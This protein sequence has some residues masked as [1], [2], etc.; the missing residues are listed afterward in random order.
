MSIKWIIISS[1]YII[2]LFIFQ[3]GFLLKKPSLDYQSKCEDFRGR[4][5]LCWNKPSFKKAIWIIIDALRYD[6]MDSGG[7]L[8]EPYKGRVKIAG[9]LINSQPNNTILSLFIADPPTTTFQRIKALTTGSLPTFIDIKDNFDAGSIDEDNIINQ[10]FLNGHNIT[11]MGDDTWT[12]LFKNKFNR[13]FPAPSFDVFDLDTVDNMVL[14]HLFDEI[15]KDD[16]NIIIGHFLG[17]D[18]CGHRYGPKHSAMLEKLDQMDNM[19]R[20]IIKQMDN[21]TILF[22]MGDHGMSNDG[23]HGGDSDLEVEAGFLAYS[24]IPIVHGKRVKK[25]FQIDF[26]PTISFLL[27]IPLP[28][29]N[30]GVVVETFFPIRELLK[31]LEINIAQVIR[32]ITA[33][34]REDSGMTTNFQTILQQYNFGLDD[35]V[36]SFFSILYLIQEQLRGVWVT[37]D[38]NLIIIGVLM[39]FDTI[40]FQITYDQDITSLS[41]ITFRSG[42]LLLSIS[43]I[44]MPKNV[45]TLE[46]IPFAL[47][48]S[49]LV[50]LIKLIKMVITKK[51]ILTS[52]SI[53]TS[54]L[55][56]F[57]LLSLF[58][59]SYI[60]YEPY[61][62]KFIIQ[63]L[64]IYN[65][66]QVF[67]QNRRISKS[68]YFNVTSFSIFVLFCGAISSELFKCREESKN[69]SESFLVSNFI[70]FDNIL[71][72]FRMIIAIGLLISINLYILSSQLSS[73]NSGQKLFLKLGYFFIGIISISWILRFV[74]NKNNTLFYNFN[75]YISLA[76]HLFVLSSLLLTLIFSPAKIFFTTFFYLSILE[77]ALVVG[78][79]SALSIVCII[80]FLVYFYIF[81]INDSQI[82]SINYYFIIS[83]GFFLLSNQTTIP[84][85]P[86]LAAFVGIPGNFTITFL[87]KLLVL[88]NLFGAV[89]ITTIFSYNIVI[90]HLNFVSVPL[91]LAFLFGVK[92]LVI[93]LMCIIHRR[94]LMLFKVF[95]PKFIFEAVNFITFLVLSTVLSIIY[96]IKTL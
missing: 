84:T 50:S 21:E 85:I 39:L 4:S 86:W 5:D 20:D 35:N 72:F 52:V 12:S 77:I 82:L 18:H 22:V 25:F 23:N 28:F 60:I 70:S 81:S 38:Y 14:D 15:A 33:Y 64:L 48:F 49:I 51:I 6:F 87:P 62:L 2:S 8:T 16:W 71:Y 78:D 69:C 89:F 42:T 36:D 29:T 47:P 32:L 41:N 57:H 13:E 92:M 65:V 27:G 3:K 31:L 67:Q 95:A 56:I 83:Y 54:I 80:S 74:V 24:K 90:K 61:V 7:K 75:F 43:L 96:H 10:L 63:T 91:N 45:L 94:H 59:N 66:V 19:L 1:S 58:S 34:G 93:C 17:V 76:T 55:Y 40:L 46:I 11:F 9:E 79:N 88:I 30:I 53:L 37:F 26:V 44:L 73:F 68:F